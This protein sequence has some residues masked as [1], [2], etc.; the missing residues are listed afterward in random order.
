M[1]VQLQIPSPVV[2]L[3][4]G[5]TTVMVCAEVSNTVAREIDITAVLDIIAG[6]ATEG[7]NVL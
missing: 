1:V 5:D 7:S 3:T 2:E 4:S 6:T